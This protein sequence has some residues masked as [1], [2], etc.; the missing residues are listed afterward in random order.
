MMQTHEDGDARVA[1]A[2]FMETL[3]ARSV[4]VLKRA[5]SEIAAGKD[6]EPVLDSWEHKFTGIHVVQRPD[7]S[8]TILRI[9]VGGGPDTVVRL[10]YCV[11]RGNRTKCAWL[12][13][14]A[15]KALRDK[16]E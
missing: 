8:Q 7:D 10:D 12:L 11:F 1:R 14:Q 3:E 16:P 9:S 13:E 4:D 15:A 6:D 2:R 5:G